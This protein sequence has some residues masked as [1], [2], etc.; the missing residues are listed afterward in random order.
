[1]EKEARSHQF[2]LNEKGQVIKEKGNLLPS[3]IVE[4]LSKKLICPILL[5]VFQDV[6]NLEK[7]SPPLYIP[8]VNLA[9]PWINGFFDY[10]LSMTDEGVLWE[11]K[12]ITE[13]TNNKLIRLQPEME[14]K[15]RA[16]TNTFLQKGDS[17][18]NLQT[19]NEE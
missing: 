13:A 10:F 1:M 17:C 6:L 16:E 4:E 11:I 15:L 3:D 18:D 12:D 7:D 9:T 5:S 8:K 19:P 2:W 14:Q